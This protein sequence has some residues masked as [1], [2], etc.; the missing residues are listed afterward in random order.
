MPF[1]H[2]NREKGGGGSPL[3]HKSSEIATDAEKDISLFYAA[4]KGAQTLRVY[5]KSSEI[6]RHEDNLKYR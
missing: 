5:H 1:I 6:S 3:Y 4:K 2:L